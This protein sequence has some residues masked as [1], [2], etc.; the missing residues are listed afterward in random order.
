MRA[1]RGAPARD[2][3]TLAEDY[4]ATR[5]CAPRRSRD[6]KDGSAAAPRAIAFARGLVSWSR[7]AGRTSW[8]FL[9]RARRLGPADRVHSDQRDM[10]CAEPE[11]RSPPAGPVVHDGG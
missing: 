11:F 7:L 9:A 4:G 8:S 3:R 2:Q 5:S 6:C 10:V 1:D